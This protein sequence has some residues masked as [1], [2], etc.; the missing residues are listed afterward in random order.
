MRDILEESLKSLKKIR[1][2]KTRLLAMLLVLSLIVSMNVFW[3][4]RRPGLTLAGDADCGIRE[5]THDESCFTQVCICE[6]PEDDHIHSEGCY[7]VQAADEAEPVLACTRTED[8]HTH[9]E[10]CY[11]T[12]LTGPRETLQLICQETAESHT[13]TDDCYAPVLEG[14]VEETVLDCQLLTEPHVHTQDCYTTEVPEEQVLICSAH[15]HGEDCYTQELHCELEEH[16]HSI[17]CY[18]DE[19]ADVETLLDWQSMFAAYPYTGDLRRDLVGI[20]KTQVGYSE[21][22]RNYEIGTDGIRRGYT[23]YGAWYGTPYRDWSAAF[24]SFCLNYAGADPDQTPGNIGAST[25]AELWKAR[26]RFA[27]VGEYVPAAGDLVFLTNNTVAIVSEVYGTTFHMIRGDMD[28]AVGT[29][30]MMLNDPCIAGWGMTVIAAADPVP[31]PTEETLPDTEEEIPADESAEET[32]PDTEEETLPDEP[33]EE[34]IP[35]PE[36]DAP[37]NTSYQISWEQMLDVSNGPV[38]FIFADVGTSQQP[39]TYSFRSTRAATDLLTYLGDNGT[40]ELRLLNSD[41]TEL[42]PDEN[43]NYTIDTAT[44][45]KLHMRIFSPNGMPPGSY[46]YQLPQG[47]VVEAGNGTLTIMNQQ[48]GESIEV[49][50]WDLTA[51]GLITLTFNNAMTNM[52]GVAIPATMSVQFSYQDE[53]IDFD[54]KITVTVNPPPETDDPTEL[55]KWGTQG[56]E[57]N[58]E[59]KT[60]NTKIYWTVKVTGHN[61]SMIPGN[62]LTDSIVNG[63]WYGTHRYTQSDI[64]GGLRIDASGPDGQWHS[65]TV[66][67][68]DPGLQWTEDGW[69]YTIP[70]TVITQGGTELTLGSNG[71][72][73]LVNY[74]TTPDASDVAGF[75]TYSNRAT[76]EDQV[77]DGYVRFQHGNVQGQIGKTGH[78]QADAAGGSFRWEVTADIP[79][80][81]PGQK[82]NF[83]FLVDNMSLNGLNIVTND[84]DKATVT[85]THNGTTLPAPHLSDATPADTF[86]WYVSW[87]ANSNGIDYGRTIT[88]LH[89]CDCTAENC[90]WWGE[91]GCGSSPWV[92]GVQHEHFCQC[93]TVEGLTTINLTYSTT[94]LSI[95]ENYGGVGNQLANYVSLNYVVN[96]NESNPLFVDDG[97]VGVTIPGMFKKVLTEDFNG[98]TAHYQITVNEAKLSL[99]N[100]SALL[101]HDE[102]TDTLAF[103]SGSMVIR[104]EDANGVSTVLQQDVDY[105]LLY[106][107]TGEKKDTA[108]NTVHVLDITLLHPQP[109][110]YIIDY[111]ATL[112]PPEGGPADVTYSN[113]ASITLWGKSFTEETPGKVYTEFGITGESYKVELSKT[114]SM[115][116][117]LLEG[118]VFGLYNAQHGQVATGETKKTENLTFITDVIQG[119]IFRHHELYYFKELKAPIGY[120]LDDTPHWFYFCNST[121]PDTCKDCASIPPEYQATRVPMD[122]VRVISI[123]NE[124]IEYHLP[125][126]GGPGIYPLITVSGL[127]V[128]TPLVYTSVQRRKRER[129]DKV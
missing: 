35:E 115:T 73:Y 29:A 15:V 113:S 129:R 101:I 21:S 117:E 91:N 38:F 104:A 97:W 26:G 54:G 83:W 108:G 55:Q 126:T 77:F 107:G 11:T 71:W 68:G 18:C 76:I 70:E 62:V 20:A 66:H 109:V 42:I 60:D 52:S 118:A 48:T 27:P 6:L 86:A 94:D 92:G 22:E 51:D 30:S 36:E 43:N 125:A 102:M 105:T 98:Y 74:T 33:A 114:D 95:V 56:Y 58:Q 128:M 110:K 99:T 13:H 14:P 80:H 72:E 63:E 119:I 32:L 3:V 45:Y 85:A 46:F 78:F 7:A 127:F 10:S 89:R 93:W 23:R 53:P 103:I 124:R 75:L 96:G 44:K 116:G 65:W 17:E 90:V 19:N 87:S 106:D 5:H 120:Q 1:A 84:A 112:I 57:G 69:A 49:G 4:L 28:G 24:V 9:E 34:T 37:G 100:G 67:Q 88:L 8:P 81:Q 41:N 61:D 121:D 59:G 82:A 40:L 39:Q 47:V 50:T 122:Q 64:D 123:T 2:Q 25:M 16:T 111:D 79:G 12:R 31:D